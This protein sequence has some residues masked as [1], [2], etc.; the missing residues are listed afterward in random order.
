M[1]A[2]PIAVAKQAPVDLDKAVARFERQLID[3][4]L[5][6]TGGNRAE[7]ARRLGISRARLLRK[8]ED[9]T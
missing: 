6:S 7:A 2:I 3:A 9:A 4:T 8:I 5:E 1:W